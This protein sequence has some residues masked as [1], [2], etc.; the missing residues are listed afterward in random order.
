MIA[1]NYWYRLGT[2]GAQWRGRLNSDLRLT[3]LKKWQ[4]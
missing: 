3:T 4:F 1:V 2:V